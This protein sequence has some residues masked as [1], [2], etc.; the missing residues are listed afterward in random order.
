[1]KNRILQVD[2]NSLTDEQLVV[3]MSLI[4]A[5]LLAKQHTQ[6]GI[7]NVDVIKDEITVEFIELCIDNNIEIERVPFYLELTP[8]KKTNATPS[9]F[10]NRSIATAWDDEGNPTATRNRKIGE[11]FRYHEKGGRFFIELVKDPKSDPNEALSTISVVDYLSATQI[12]EV[13]DTFTTAIIG[14]YASMR[15]MLAELATIEEIE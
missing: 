12:K 13:Y 5:K 3:L 15:A 14:K 1:M 4:Q 7:I 2:R 10:P 9:M 6:N 11:Y 8:S